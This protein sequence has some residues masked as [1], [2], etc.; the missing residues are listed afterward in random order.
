MTMEL[1]ATPRS[2]RLETRS[3]F[4]GFIRDG[5][6]RVGKSHVSISQGK[7][8]V[9]VGSGAFMALDPPADMKLYPVPHRRRDSP[10]VS[11]VPES[12][13]KESEKEIIRRADA[14]LEN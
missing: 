5:K 11:L 6:G 10:P 12:E 2:G 9:G 8:S 7:E 4:H 1:T 13:L 14:A 3:S